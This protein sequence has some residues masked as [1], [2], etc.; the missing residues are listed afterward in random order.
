MSAT[1][2]FSANIHC[3][4][5]NDTGFALWSVTEMDAVCVIPPCT[6]VIVHVPVFGTLKD[7]V[8]PLPVDFVI[9]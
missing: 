7:T 6:A 8:V 9:E 1:P 4:K 3:S 2:E 5:T